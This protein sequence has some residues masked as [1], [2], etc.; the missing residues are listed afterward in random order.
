MP[1]V[2]SQLL[3]S[4]GSSAWEG[5]ARMAGLS[6]G[7]PADRQIASEKPPGGYCWCWIEK[8]RSRVALARFACV[9]SQ[10]IWRRS[11][12]LDLALTWL[13]SH[14]CQVTFQACS[15]QLNLDQEVQWG[16]VCALWG[17]CHVLETHQLFSK[18]AG[19]CPMGHLSRN[20]RTVSPTQAVLR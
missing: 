2:V 19:I 17:C 1:G 13:S 20:S 12:S 6:T 4:S 7:I 3:C 5:R 9:I 11:L 18:G 16:C 10:G 8:E 14:I 15:V